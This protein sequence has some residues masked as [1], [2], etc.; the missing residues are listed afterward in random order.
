MILKPTKRSDDVKSY[1]PISL[2]PITSK[3]MELL[4]LKELTPILE[5]QRL[6]P[7][8]QFG[9]RK[10]TWH[11]W[12]SSA[13]RWCNKC[14]GEMH[15]EKKYCTAVFLDISQAIDKVWHDGLLYKAKKLLPISFFNFLRSYIKDR[16]IFVQQGKSATNLHTRWNSGT[17]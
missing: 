14:S 9:F 1:R 10:K 17:L 2:L 7:D 16:Y 8:H 4:L 12:T 11:H 15:E 3:I 13:S 5:A 6:I